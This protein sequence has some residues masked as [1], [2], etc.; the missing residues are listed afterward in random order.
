MTPLLE[1]HVDLYSDLRR[2]FVEQGRRK[3][4]LSLTSCT[5]ADIEP[6]DVIDPLRVKAMLGVL[7]QLLR[8]QQAEQAGANRTAQDAIQQLRT[9]NRR[10]Y[11]QISRER[12]APE[13]SDETPSPAR[14]TVISPP[15][16]SDSPR[17]RAPSAA[18]KSPW[19]S[20]AASSP[21]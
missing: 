19:S 10:L 6:Q 12:N 4:Q 7:A 13:S 3:Q 21:P 11:D 8:Q 20:R 1:Q 18:P 9:E 16:K 14:I 17:D 2:R 15:Y 5:L